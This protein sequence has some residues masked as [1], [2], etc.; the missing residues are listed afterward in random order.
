MKML[1]PAIA[2]IACLAAAPAH[3]QVYGSAGYSHLASDDDEIDVEVGLLTGRIGGRI[4]DYLGAEA[5]GSFG[6][7]E[8]EVV[9]MDVPIEMKVKYV[10]A[11]YAVGFVPLGDNFELLGRVGIGTAEVEASSGDFDISETGSGIHYGV[12]AQLWFAENHGVRA[13]YTRLESIKS[14]VFSIAYAFR[15]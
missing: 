6:L 10:L 12:G 9:F 15:F 3:A 13:D 2:A 5:E 11:G 14:N 1:V 4:N 7:G 8:D